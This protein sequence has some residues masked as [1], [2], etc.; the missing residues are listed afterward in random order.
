MALLKVSRASGNL[1]ELGRSLLIWY[2]RTIAGVLIAA[3]VLA[4]SNRSALEKEDRDVSLLVWCRK[5][6]GVH[7]SLLS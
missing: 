3:G 7:Q 6:P 4:K 5:P 2:S 1:F